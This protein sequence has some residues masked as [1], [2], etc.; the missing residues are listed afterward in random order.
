MYTVHFYYND[1][2]LFKFL[3]AHGARTMPKGAKD[4]IQREANQLA[5]LK[6]QLDGT[7]VSDCVVMAMGHTHQ[8][9]KQDP[10]V[11]NELLITS[12]EYDLHQHTRPEQKQNLNYI[13]PERR[14]YVNTGSFR[15]LYAKPGSMV[16][17][18]A[19]IG[20]L[21]PTKLGWSEVNVYDGEVAGITLC[22]GSKE[23]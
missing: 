4:P 18:Y 11:D 22:E 10:T 19:E 1:Q 6:R 2:L 8:L 5:W 15:K 3:V 7:G 16:F 23:T 17:D 12:S 14:W 13:A 21:Q 9:K 20:M